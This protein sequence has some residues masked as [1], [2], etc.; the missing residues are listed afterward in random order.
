MT[1]AD[2][3]VPEPGPEAG[4]EDLQ[5]DIER[6]RSQL[7]QTVEALSDKLDVKAQAKQK[8]ADT[9]DRLASK[10]QQAKGR[11]VDTAQSLRSKA[12]DVRSK[13]ADAATDDQGSIRPA[14][15]KAGIAVA[16]AV[17]IGIGVGMRRR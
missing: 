2:R 11:A 15:P 3:S 17:A 12:A 7:G 9:R 10:T 5:A 4:I 16:V 14:V 13:V 8:A 6:T 1:E